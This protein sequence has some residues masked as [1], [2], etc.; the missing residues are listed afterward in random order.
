[1]TS[2]MVWW[3]ASLVMCI[4]STMFLIRNRPQ[5]RGDC[6]RSSLASRSGASALG[7]GTGLLPRSVIS[8]ERISTERSSAEASTRTVTGTSGRYSLPCSIAFI[9]ASATA[10]LSLSRRAGGRPRFRTASATNS[11]ASRSF[12]GSLGRAK[13]ARVRHAPLRPGP[14]T[15]SPPIPLKHHESDVVLLLPALPHELPQLGEA[16]FDEALASAAV[17]DDL[18][19]PWR[20]EHL[21]GRV[22]RLDEAVAVEQDAVTGSEV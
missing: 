1:M 20:A 14:L 22:V 15:S 6:S 8:T 16:L 3:T 2:S 4:S 5:P 10:V 7:A 11:I 17:L 21:A 12:P 9:V 18:L 13:S 19:E